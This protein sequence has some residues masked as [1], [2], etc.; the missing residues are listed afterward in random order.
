MLDNNLVLSGVVRD[1]FCYMGHPKPRLMH[2]YLVYVVRPV[3]LIAD[4]LD[5]AKQAA[6]LAKAD[7]ATSM[8][9]EMTALAGVMGRYY[10]RHQGKPVKVAQANPY[11]CIPHHLFI[12]I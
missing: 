12:S 11:T 1:L 9:T 8:V 2:V 6:S 3:I 7:L 5:T 4:C 10:A